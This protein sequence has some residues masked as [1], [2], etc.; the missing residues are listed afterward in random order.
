MLDGDPDM[1]LLERYLPGGYFR[2]LLEVANTA[3]TDRSAA[4][5]LLSQADC[6]PIDEVLRIEENKLLCKSFRIDAWRQA[7]LS[8]R[9]EIIKI[10]PDIESYG[11]IPDM[12]IN[13]V[14][15]CPNMFRFMTKNGDTRRTFYLSGTYRTADGEFLNLLVNC[16]NETRLT[17]IDEMRGHSGA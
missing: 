4:L 15:F 5:R 9:G 2:Q 11:E 17:Y 14:T 1:K 16:A 7:L 10:G 8:T 12:N 6:P 13:G 3:V